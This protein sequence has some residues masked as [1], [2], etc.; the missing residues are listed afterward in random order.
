MAHTLSH[1]YGHLKG[2]LDRAC[3]AVM[4]SDMQTFWQQCSFKTTAAIMAYV[5]QLRWPG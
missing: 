3:D 1:D 2:Q 4:L 5:M